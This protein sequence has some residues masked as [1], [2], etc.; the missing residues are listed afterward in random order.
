M[1]SAADLAHP[2]A[3][4]VAAGTLLC[5]F[6]RGVMHKIFDFAWF[7]HALAEY[8]ILPRS[9]A[10]PVA[11]VL[12]VAEAVVAL[13]LLIPQ[14]RMI[15]ATGAAVLLAIYAA[16]IAV[17][18]VRGRSSIDC[19]CGGAGQGL[20]WFLVLRNAVLVGFALVAA[21]SPI[22]AGIGP[23][24]WIAALAAI[25]SFWLLIVVTEKLA[26]NLSYLAAADATH[27]HL[28]HAETH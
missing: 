22:A 8:R 26:E 2:I 7:A 5:V 19:G 3:I 17:N 16:S 20:S 13:G 14:I 21:Q 25:A 1:P 24:G 4:I 28:H 9:I 11:I 27:D 10:T 18:L 15:A 23:S 12:T 6:L